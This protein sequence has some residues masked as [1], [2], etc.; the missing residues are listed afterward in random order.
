MSIIVILVLFGPNI[1]SPITHGR[2]PYSYWSSGKGEI[3][4]S[5]GQEG[6]VIWYYLTSKIAENKKGVAVTVNCSTTWLIAEKYLNE[7]N[8]FCIIKKEK[9]SITSRCVLALILC[10]HLKLCFELGKTGE[11]CCDIQTEKTLL[12]GPRKTS[13][14]WVSNPSTP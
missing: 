2:Q 6:F 14:T 4:L 13:C 8:L 5:C 7:K 11:K 10:L 3:I 1:L 9:A 12:V